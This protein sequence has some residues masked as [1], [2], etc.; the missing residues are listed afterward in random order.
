MFLPGFS[1][2]RFSGCLVLG[3]F[4][5]IRTQPQGRR[6]IGSMPAAAL[7]LWAAIQQPD[8]PK[9]IGQLGQADPAAR[10][11]IEQTLLEAGE[12]AVRPLIESGLRSRDPKVRA[13][14]EEL[15]PRLAAVS[16]FSPRHER[17]V[18]GVLK[19][20]GTDRTRRLL[21]IRSLTNRIGPAGWRFWEVLLEDPDPMVR[22]QAARALMLEASEAP[23][24]FGG[25]GYV[26]PIVA[27][28]LRIGQMR[29]IVEEPLEAARVL[30]RAA[31][32]A[33]GPDDL[34]ALE[35]VLAHRNA[36]VRLLMAE[37]LVHFGGAADAAWERLI[38]DA[39]PEPRAALYHA[40]ADLHFEKPPAQ[41][42]GLLTSQNARQ[43]LGA[44]IH[45]ARAGDERA[46]AAL[47]ALVR[48]DPSAARVLGGLAGPAADAFF[49]KNAEK[50]RASGDL[51]LLR[52]LGDE[53]SRRRAMEA[54]LKMTHADPMAPGIADWLVASER[55]VAA[56][57]SMAPEQEPQGVLGSCVARRELVVRGTIAQL[58][59]QPACAPAYA[60]LRGLARRD[61]L[62]PDLEA[63]VLKVL[64]D[65]AHPGFASAAQLWVPGTPEEALGVVLKLSSGSAAL[66]A[67]LRA[68][69]RF[70]GAGPEVLGKLRSAMRD[71]SRQAVRPA[72][73]I[74]LARTAAAEDA[75]LLRPL[76]GS[77]STSVRAAAVEGLGRIGDASVFGRA[78]TLHREGK[79]PGAV[80]AIAALDP[81]RSREWLLERLRGDDETDAV[82]AAAVLAERDDAEA[83]ALIRRI[84]R[85]EPW[86][87]DREGRT[88]L[89]IHAAQAKAEAA[90]LLLE[91]TARGALPPGAYP[92][93]LALEPEPVLE[94]LQRGAWRRHLELLERVVHRDFYRARPKPV[95]WMG[96]TAPELGPALGLEVEIDPAAPL[97]IPPAGSYESA[98]ALLRATGA[99]YRRVDGTRLRIE[100]APAAWAAWEAWWEARPKKQ[101]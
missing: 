67:A 69:P 53:P 25:S 12:P 40:A 36:R 52:R 92:L 88:I 80:P 82:A 89:E 65:P 96:T 9:L 90:P 45:L 6:I 42:A 81:A 83:R 33:A 86:I 31:W 59:A 26:G 17:D 38:K 46:M 68:A 70:D 49:A 56:L 66:G 29:A 77:E 3:Q 28:L 85:T 84:A 63:F 35:P 27:A 41:L 16:Y 43:R 91:L 44:S 64:S 5:N 62:G 73:G 93:V 87:V 99:P 4:L 94:A 57:W 24:S 2:G 54:V 79:L 10:A 55:D 14:A 71:P 34:A 39:D 23:V 78:V 1:V 48:S 51:G 22:A 74:L 7:V 60:V 11:R 97:R 50:I 13:A 21:G 76:L 8:Y 15:M 75:A 100:S 72:L 30:A 47:L 20:G 101:P 18:I 37:A 32:S 19:Q 61:G 95:R 58:E 98:E